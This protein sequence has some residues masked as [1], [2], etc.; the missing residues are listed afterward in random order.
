MIFRPLV[1]FADADFS[2]YWNLTANDISQSEKVW[3][4]TARLGEQG[5]LRRHLCGWDTHRYK[6]GHGV[7]LPGVCSLLWSTVPAPMGHRLHFPTVA[8]LCIH[9]FTPFP[10]FSV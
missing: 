10:T 3:K 8:D 4:E 5:R 6:R 9:F 1:E 7:R 2:R